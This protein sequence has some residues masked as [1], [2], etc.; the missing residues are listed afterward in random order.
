MFDFISSYV[1]NDEIKYVVCQMLSFP[2]GWIY[3]YLIKSNVSLENR[4][5]F[6]FLMGCL[7][8]VL[9]FRMDSIHLI[10]LILINYLLLKIVYIQRFVFH[11]SMVIS[12][13]YLAYLHYRRQFILNSFYELDVT[14]PFMLM[15]QRVTYVSQMTVSESKTSK[16][17]NLRSIPLI[18]YLCY[19]LFFPAVLSGPVCDY[20]YFNEFIVGHHLKI[21]KHNSHHFKYSLLMICCM[22]IIVGLFFLIIGIQLYNY[23]NYYLLTSSISMNIWFPFKLIIA[24]FVA[25]TRYYFA[26]LLSD[27]SCNNC[28]FGLNYHDQ[29]G[30]WDALIGVNIIKI[31]T[32]TSLKVLLDN[33]NLSTTKWLKRT[34]Y[35]QSKF[36][37]VIMTYLVSSLWHGFYFGYYATFLSTAFLTLAARKVRKVVRPIIYAYECSYSWL[38]KFYDFLTWFTTHLTLSYMVGPFVVLKYEESILFWRNCYFFG[39]WLMIV[40]F[41][42]NL[43]VPKTL[44]Y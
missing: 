39:H 13:V 41:V 16:N 15:V 23:S 20:Q 24:A 9:C 21:F 6:G 31:E 26:Y 40:P 10:M 1:R 38:P 18:D 22:K 36:Q 3:N 34:V 29:N 7:L 25:R 17:M 35:S 4:K 30:S 14:G 12:L 44:K 5:V 27:S 11:L 42:L 37:P 33:Y 32:A 8:I 28:G 19:C 43:F 2:I